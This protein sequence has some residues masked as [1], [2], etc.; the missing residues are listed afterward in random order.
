M[1]LSYREIA[2]LYFPCERSVLARLRS[3]FTSPVDSWAME[4][5]KRKAA[6]EAAIMNVGK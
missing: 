5:V 1:T 2:S 3:W 4:P 6:V